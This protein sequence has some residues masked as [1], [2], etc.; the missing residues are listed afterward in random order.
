MSD[1][2]EKFK[3]NNYRMLLWVMLVAALGGGVPAFSKMALEVIPTF[4][5]I[6]LRFIAA[7]VILFPIF[8]KVKEKISKN[9]FWFLVLVSVF[10]TGN[11]IF[12]AFGVRETTAT[13][14]QVLYA[15]VPIVALIA[16]TIIL[17]TQFNKNKILGVLLGLVGVL[18]II[19][20]PRLVGNQNSAGS[21]IGNLLVLTAVLSYSLYTVLSKK[22]Q[23]IYSPLILTTMMVITT[24]VIQS[25][26][27]ISE[28]SD[29]SRTI[30]NITL[31]GIIGV[32]YVGTIGTGLYFL[33][34]QMVIKKADPLIASMTFYLQ[35]IFSF[36][37]AFFLL[38][39]RLSLSLIV[40][41][42]L[43]FLGAGLV[44]RKDGL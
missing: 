6:F 4:T 28:F 41:S 12:F 26:L 1:L 39:E 44:T 29:Y 17:K 5:F 3:N 27:I 32:I 42:L 7:A 31:K 35:P 38:G 19:M 25:F 43:A 9:D 37:W 11:V 16:S 21:I 10:G 18:I 23:K 2:W 40:G 36:I 30:D 34:Y 20:T 13:V 15:A 33:I 22:A 8:I 14:A 24:L